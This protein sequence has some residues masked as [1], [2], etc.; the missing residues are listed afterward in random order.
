M[1]SFT[2][3]S[4]TI[5][6]RLE[7]FPPDMVL[8]SQL[9][10]VPSLFC[11]SLRVWLI[12]SPDFPFEGVLQWWPAG[13]GHPVF[14]WVRI[15]GEKWSDSCPRKSGEKAMRSE[16]DCVLGAQK[17]LKVNLIKFGLWKTSVTLVVCQV[18]IC[19]QNIYNDGG[20]SHH[21]HYQQVLNFFSN[22]LSSNSPG[23]HAW[24]PHSHSPTHSILTTTL[25]SRVS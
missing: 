11:L 12:T 24:I 1:I 6:L 23:Q 13:Q 19:Q 10:L 14:V 15:A 9:N 7:L 21:H 16:K 17:G 18:S 5:V 22:H 25:W 2:G 20:R 4:T 8:L 3:Y